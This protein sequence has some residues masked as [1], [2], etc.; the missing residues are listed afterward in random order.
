[1]V[2]DMFD[3]VLYA[4]AMAWRTVDC[5]D[6]SFLTT[7]VCFALLTQVSIPYVTIGI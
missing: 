5:V 4:P 6:L 3:T 1:M 7:W 2:A